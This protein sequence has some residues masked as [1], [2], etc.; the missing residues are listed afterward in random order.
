MWTSVLFKCA[1]HLAAL[2]HATGC[3]S[4]CPFHLKCSDLWLILDHKEA[5]NILLLVSFLNAAPSVKKLVLNPHH[6]VFFLRMHVN[7]FVL[8]P[9]L[10]YD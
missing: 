8:N 2:V 10:D 7:I 1:R 4:I 5:G 9:R 6:S 3:C